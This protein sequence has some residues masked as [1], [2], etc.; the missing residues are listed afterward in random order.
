MTLVKD[1]ALGILPQF[2]EQGKLVKEAILSCQLPEVFKNVK[3]G[4]PI[5]FDDGKIEGIIC[6]VGANQFQVKIINAKE[7][8]SKLKAEKGIN[9]P[10][11]DLG[12]SGLTLKDKVDLSFVAHHADI[13]NFSFVNSAEDVEELYTELKALGV[14]QKLSVVLK[15]ETRIAFENLLPILLSA[16]KVNTIG[17]MIA[18]GDLAIETGWQHIG[19]V[20]DEILS[21]CSAAHVPVIWATQVLEN[22][23]KSG[24]PSRSEM[25]DVSSSLKAECVMLNKGPYVNE[26]IRLLDKI[27]ISS[28]NHRQKK[29]RMLPQ[30]KKVER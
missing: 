19:A 15:I 6:G 8:G 3:Q 4:E 25:T 29:E 5:F 16:M 11:I 13:I 30:M 20:Q 23:A 26:A 12:I 28:E 17:V 27:L 9:L 1:K 21:T 10:T 24:L 7:S 18:R 22:L 2:N 14:L